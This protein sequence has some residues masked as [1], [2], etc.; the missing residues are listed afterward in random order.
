MRVVKDALEPED[1][2]ENGK[3]FPDAPV[4]VAQLKCKLQ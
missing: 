4:I 2:E 3:V 1:Y